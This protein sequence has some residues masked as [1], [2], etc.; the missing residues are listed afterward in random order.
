M[1]LK[2]EEAT[3]NAREVANK[4]AQDSGSELGGIKNANQ[5]QFSI[6]SEETTPQINKIRVVTTVDYILK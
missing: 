4:F 3:R 6:D 1:V 2:W 5:G